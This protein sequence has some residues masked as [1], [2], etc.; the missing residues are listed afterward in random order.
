MGDCSVNEGSPAAPSMDPTAF[1]GEGGCLH[2]WPLDVTTL[3]SGA[4]SA[5]HRS[6]RRRH[7][8]L[9]DEPCQ[10]NG[11]VT[12]SLLPSCCLVQGRR[13]MLFYF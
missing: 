8:V 5:L 2:L 6:G 3:P 12:E 1:G 10:D 13:L 4:R 11:E 7:V 9:P